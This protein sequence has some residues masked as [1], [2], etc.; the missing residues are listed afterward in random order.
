MRNL[1]RVP[2]TL[3][4][5]IVDWC[6]HHVFAGAVTNILADI[7]DTPISPELLPLDAHGG[8]VQAAEDTIGPFALHD[9]FRF[10]VVRN[11]FPPAKILFLAGQAFGGEYSRWMRAFYSRFFFSQFKRSSVPDGPIGGFGRAVATGGLEDAE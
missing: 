5:Y 4:R 10:H 9:F 3:V 11:H 1:L 8:M 6:A 2:K 7:R